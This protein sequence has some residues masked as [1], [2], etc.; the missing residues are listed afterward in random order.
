MSK[1]AS[2]KVSAVLT[3]DQIKSTLVEYGAARE[4]LDVFAYK[5]DAGETYFQVTDNDSPVETA[6]FE[7][8]ISS[9]SLSIN[10]ELGI[11]KY[12]KNEA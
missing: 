10:F 7:W 6:L 2:G 11:Y 5:V 9:T 3:S 4:S 1:R 12:G 8:A